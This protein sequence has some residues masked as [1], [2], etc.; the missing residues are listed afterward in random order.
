[1]RN[2]YN[3]TVVNNHTTVTRMSFRGGPGG[4]SARATAQELRAANQRHVS[5]TS[6]QTQHQEAARTDRALLAS[7]NHGRPDVAASLRPGEFHGRGPLNK[8]H[9]SQ[10]KTGRPRGNKPSGNESLG[11]S[12]KAGDSR[13]SP[14]LSSATGCHSRQSKAGAEAAE[15]S[16][17]A[18]PATGCG[19]TEDAKPTHPGE[20]KTR[21]QQSQSAAA[22]RTSAAPT[23][24]I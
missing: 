23:A 13:K 15:R 4:T 10:S 20:A 1:M 12:G 17:K 22:G 14:A 7:V 9:G 11:Y 16:G 3:T 8:G 24:A 5:M 18:A 19:A 6:V 21:T 2:T